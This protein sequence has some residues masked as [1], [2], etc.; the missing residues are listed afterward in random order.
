VESSGA[1][2]QL[3]E[4]T[5]AAHPTLLALLAPF[6]ADHRAHAQAIDP[7]LAASPT[8]AA[9]TS[10][11]GVPASTASPS[12]SASATATPTGA[13]P[14]IPAVPPDP[15]AALAALAGAETAASASARADAVGAVEPALARL[16]A[17]IAASR[18]LHAYLLDAG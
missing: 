3:H 18:A 16:L 15:D 8:P 1:L 2:V 13:G 14:T 7:E 10:S 12:S 5:V 4:A 6:L 11:S 9:A 17:S